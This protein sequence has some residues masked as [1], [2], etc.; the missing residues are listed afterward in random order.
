METIFPIF[1]DSSQLLPMETVFHLTETYWKRGNG[2][3]ICFLSIVLSRDFF[4]KWKLLL[5]LGGSQFLKNES[6]S[7]QWIP[8]FKIFWNKEKNVL[9]ERAHSG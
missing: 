9:R 1:L 2:V 4:C 3:F 6:Y 8:I 7:C 5:K